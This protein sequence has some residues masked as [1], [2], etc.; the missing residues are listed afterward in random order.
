MDDDDL[1][2]GYTAT[3]SYKAGTGGFGI[4]L[5]FTIAVLAPLKVPLKVK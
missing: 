2:G 5:V 4:T 1:Y 3:S